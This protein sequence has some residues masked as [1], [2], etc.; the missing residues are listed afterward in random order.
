MYIF[1]SVLKFISINTIS[2]A[3]NGVNEISNYDNIIYIRRKHLQVSLRRFWL[4]FETQK[5]LIN[6]SIYNIIIWLRYSSFSAFRL[7]LIMKIM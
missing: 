6:N 1:R 3:V 5:S 7:R 4:R 2:E